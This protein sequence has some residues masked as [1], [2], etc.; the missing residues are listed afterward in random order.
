[1][2]RLSAWMPCVAGL[3][4]IFFKLSGSISVFDW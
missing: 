1:L 2:T 4:G 3:Y